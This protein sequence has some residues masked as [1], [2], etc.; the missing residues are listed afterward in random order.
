MQFARVVRGVAS[1]CVVSVLAACGGGGGGGDEPRTSTVTL[2]TST[3]AT[4]TG[5]VSTQNH[6]KFT[7]DTGTSLGSATSVEFKF[8]NGAE[9]GFSYIN[10]DNS[11]YILGF[12]DASGDYMCGS[13]TA[14]A[15]IGIATCPNNIQVDL[16]RKIV[17]FTNAELEDFD[18]IQ[19][20][21]RISGNLQWN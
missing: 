5:T 16:G 4:A 17:T 14:T 10:S 15:A 21:I 3:S 12:S 18:A 6:R 8:S 13:A 1:A 2:E 20:N 9:A 7:E 11:I 19:P